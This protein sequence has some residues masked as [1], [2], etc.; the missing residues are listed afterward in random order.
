[1]PS[2]E[3]LPLLWTLYRRLALSSLRNPLLRAYLPWM[4]RVAQRVGRRLPA[5][6]DVDD[7]VSHGVMGLIRAIEAFDPTRGVRFETFAYPHVRFA[8]ID[9]LREFD[10]A[11]RKTR[12]LLR[13]LEQV[14]DAIRVRTGI[15]ATDAE[16]AGTMGLSRVEFGKLQ[17]RRRALCGRPLSVG[18][19]GDDDPAAVGADRTP[20]R[21]AVDPARASAARQLREALVRDLSTRERLTI[22]L[23]YC[24]GLT[25]K[26][27]GK[28]L[29]LSEARV[30]QIHAS[31]IRRLR[32][33]FAEHTPANLLACA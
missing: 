33:R 7:L 11:D 13:R 29:G 30:A 31:V 6:V 16:L 10:P 28:V 25:M 32:A 19:R 3:S 24:E 1:M 5:S 27:I 22:L 9:G 4:T 18:V 21:R 20:D 26:E 8:M 15:P 23:Y 17:L 14:S 12:H 2:P